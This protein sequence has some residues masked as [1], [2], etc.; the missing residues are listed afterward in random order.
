MARRR[1]GVGIRVALGAQR[2]EILAMVDSARLAL[3]GCRQA[4]RWRQGALW[5]RCCSA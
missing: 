5:E 4:W 1:G 2:G 3:L